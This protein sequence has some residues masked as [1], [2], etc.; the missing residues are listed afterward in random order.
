[1]LRGQHARISMTMRLV[2]LVAT[3]LAFILAFYIRFY[4]NLGPPPLHIP[5]WSLYQPVL[6]LVNFI[7]FGIV[8]SEKYEYPFGVERHD[9]YRVLR[10][11]VIGLVTITALSFLYREASYSRLVLIYF[12][13]LDGT[14]RVLAR[15]LLIYAQRFT[16][17]KQGQTQRIVIIGADKVAERL[18][19][20]FRKYPGLGFHVVD[21]YS[22]AQVVADWH[23]GQITLEQGAAQMS[24]RLSELVNTYNVDTALLTLSLE[25]QRYT[26]EMIRACETV[27]LNVT[28]VPGFATH[29]GQMMQSTNIGGIT[30]LE[31][32][33]SPLQDDMNM[34]IKRAMDVVFALVA[35]I[36]TAPLML[37]IAI[38]TKLTSP[39]PVIFKQVRIGLHNKPFVMY[40]FRSMKV[41]VEADP[42][43]TWT[44]ENDPRQTKWGSLIRKT[45]LDELPQ[46][47]N[48]LKGDMSVV[49]PRPERPYFVEQFSQEIPHY[50]LRHQVRVGI[51]GWAQ[52]NG[53]RGDT[54]IPDRVRADLQYIENWSV[55]TDLKI[56]WLT[57]WRG[58]F[59][60]QAY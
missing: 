6:L 20:L 33:Y 14:L 60:K 44:I 53:L 34:L 37:L 46:F 16:H 10:G 28:V 7:W 42:D 31:L 51:T 8:I 39:G 45:S 58:M 18:S 55:L 11:T 59:S 40:K 35:I 12:G 47:F 56:I 24:K 25:E 41:D 49:G 48:V 57:V 17:K 50:R 23:T 13:V 5:E 43:T 9:L 52:V 19:Q 4:S 2:E 30:L 54:S 3:N 32:Y 26:P 21:H 38:I 1:M 29:P 36:I 15:E 27:G 22:I